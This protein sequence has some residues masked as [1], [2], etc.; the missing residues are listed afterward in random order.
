MKLGLRGRM[1]LLAFLPAT[2]VASLLTAVFLVRAIDDLKQGL[3]ISGAAISRQLATA[4][5]FGLFAGQHATLAALTESAVRID[6]QVSGSAIVDARGTVVARS[7]KLDVSSWPG[8]EGI[9]GH[10][11]GSS[12]LLFVTPIMSRNLAVNDVYGGT[13]NTIA[14]APIVL[15]H[16]LVEL[17]L[18]EISSRGERLLAIGLMM[19][20][21]GSGL[22]GWLALWIA[23]AVTKPLLETNA[24]V[25][26]IGAGD[27]T[28]RVP[29]DSAGALRSLAR[30][31][32]HMAGQIGVT[33]DELKARVAEATAD[34]KR[35]KEAAEH[36][37]MA[38]S[39]FLASASHDLR[40]PLHALGLLVSALARSAVAKI[41]PKLIA[42][43]ESAVGSLQHLLDA[44]LDI[45]RLDGGN[46][47]PQVSTFPLG[48]ILYR[49][50]RDFSP[51]A[52]QKGLE[53]R[54]RRT[55]A[56]VR[57]DPQI[58]ERI[59]LNLVAN[60]LRY[61]RTG[62]VLV[63]CRRRQEAMRVEVWD[64]GEGIPEHAREKIF[65]EY[66]QLENPERDGAKGLGLGLAICHRLAALL[67][68]P[69]GVRSWPGRGSVFWFELPLINEVAQTPSPH[70]AAVATVE[71]APEAARIVGTILVVE[72]DELVRSGMEQNIR[73]WGGHVL[74]AANRDEALQCCRQ[75]AVLPDLAICP[76]RLSDQ[77]RGIDLAEELRRELGPISILLVSTETSEEERFA[78]R[79]AG[80]PMLK[81]PV[82]PARLR[83]AVQ[84]LL[85]ARPAF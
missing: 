68:M 84:Q 31:I 14:A 59:L 13:E 67:G 46:V 74:L 75:S 22:G 12:A 21:L 6:S 7:G 27:L 65:E 17:S 66:V 28:A 50:A 48:R 56:R 18:A 16:A 42:Q 38:K 81:K 60:A 54:L 79:D 80:F 71:A 9:E 45:S 43:V 26:R 51:L 4:A 8:Y 5:E 30:G 19:A 63:G 62:G 41:E 36:A 69:I 39:Y 20:L 76:G 64:T 32:N 85:A 61:T 83:A 34:L 2:L 47:V 33:Q 58:I 49:L 78:A 44:I 70:Q 37:N 40:Q 3:D 10:R 1:L 29:L 57:S 77:V 15:G 35:E 25:G 23:Q 72:E 82:P 73:A 53:L 24:V 52:E 55:K 11:H